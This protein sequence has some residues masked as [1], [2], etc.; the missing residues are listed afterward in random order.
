MFMIQI[1]TILIYHATSLAH[2]VQKG[3]GIFFCCNSL[4]GLAYLV[5]KVDYEFVLRGGLNDH[6]H[7]M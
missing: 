6:G 5:L 7:E 2:E 3:T 1:A 4:G